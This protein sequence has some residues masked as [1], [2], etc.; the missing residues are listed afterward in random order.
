MPEVPGFDG[1]LDNDRS[2]SGLQPYCGHGYSNLEMTTKV[3]LIVIEIE[4]WQKRS[5]LLLLDPRFIGQLSKREEASVFSP[6]S[7][8]WAPAAQMA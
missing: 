7:E 1:H 6:S 4:R 8:P 3:R 5:A 2:S